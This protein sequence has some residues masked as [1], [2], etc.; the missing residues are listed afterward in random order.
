MAN[1]IGVVFHQDNARPHTSV[2]TRQEL[3]EL[4]WTLLSPNAKILISEIMKMNDD[5]EFKTKEFKA[6]I[7]K[8]AEN[9]KQSKNYIIGQ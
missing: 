8:P 2:V 6:S 1:K 4:G 5:E 3:W 7:K 9:E